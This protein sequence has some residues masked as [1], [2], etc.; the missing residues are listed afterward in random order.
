MRRLAMGFFAYVIVISSSLL[1][2]IAY[3]I[4]CWYAIWQLCLSRQRFLQELFKGDEHEKGKNVES[5]S[6]TRKRL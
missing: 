1:S 5:M 4:L 2:C 3:L 6:K